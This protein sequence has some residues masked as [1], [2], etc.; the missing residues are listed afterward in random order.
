[1]MVGAKKEQ[2]MSHLK[3]GHPSIAAAILQVVTL[4]KFAHSLKIK[5]RFLQ[6]RADDWM[7]TSRCV[8]SANAGILCEERGVTIAVLRKRGAEANQM[9]NERH[10][11]ETGLLAEE[12]GTSRGLL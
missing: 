10:I 6:H 1:M 12:E 2:L 9:R 3:M 4:N 7:R 8:K 11:R 5:V